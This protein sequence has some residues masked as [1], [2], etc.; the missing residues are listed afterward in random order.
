MGMDKYRVI[1]LF[2]IFLLIA[3]APADQFIETRFCG[4][5]DRNLDGT[6]IRSTKV[7]TEYKKIHPCPSTKITFGSCSG[8][9]MDHVIPL[10]CGGCDSVSNIQWLPTEMW[11]QKSLW[12]RNIY[13]GKNISKGCP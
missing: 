13:G 10:A 9:I 2:I 3:A 7:L 11:K 5:P 12:E 4:I 1:F 6:I 8:W